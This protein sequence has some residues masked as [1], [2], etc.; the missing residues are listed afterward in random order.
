MW[1]F[2]KATGITAGGEYAALG[3]LGI[4]ITSLGAGCTLGVAD[5][6][7]SQTLAK[8]GWEHCKSLLAA[9]EFDVL[10]FDELTLP[11]DFGWLDTADI[12]DALRSR[13]EGTHVVITGRRA[14]AELIEAADLVTEMRVIKH[15]YH[16][17]KLR[18]QAGIDV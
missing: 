5:T 10:V 4:E 1:Q 2:M 18:A 12:V 13:S 17:K 14:S 11:L 15:P 16:E 7:D 3:R 6:R 9:G 8:D